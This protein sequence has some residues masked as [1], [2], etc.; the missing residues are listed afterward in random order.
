LFIVY[1]KDNAKLNKEIAINKLKKQ[2]KNMSKNIKILDSNN[3]NDKDGKKALRSSTA[4][5][6]QLQ[7]STQT[8][9]KAIKKKMT[10][11]GGDSYSNQK[12]SKKLKL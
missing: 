9:V 1:L 6:K 8:S 11:G 7:E 2:A 3:K 5:F 4:F 10:A 12:S